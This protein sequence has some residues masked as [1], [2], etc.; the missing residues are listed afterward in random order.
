MAEN[1]KVA[2]VTQGNAQRTSWRELNSHERLTSQLD[3]AT[4]FLTG[5]QQRWYADFPKEE[6]R[7]APTGGNK[8]IFGDGGCEYHQLVAHGGTWLDPATGHIYVN[9]ASRP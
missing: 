7:P 9:S 1:I 8:I 3:A 5:D 2:A 6:Y 4:G